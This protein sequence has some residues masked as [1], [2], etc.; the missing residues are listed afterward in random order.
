M[1]LK[2][3]APSALQDAWYWIIGIDC[4]F[5]GRR[6]FG[7]TN[8]QHNC[9]ETRGKTFV[10]EMKMVADAIR[11]AYATHPADRDIHTIYQIAEELSEMGERDRDEQE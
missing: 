8:W 4:L 3:K 9:P 7:W 5:C 2:D 1:T 6:T 10:E 11:R